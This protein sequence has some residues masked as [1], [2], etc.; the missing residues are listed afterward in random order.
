[1]PASHDRPVV[2]P[3]AAERAR[4]LPAAPIDQSKALEDFAVELETEQ[5]GPETHGAVWQCVKTLTETLE[6]E[7]AEALRRSRSRASV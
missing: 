6:P 3:R 5:S 4:R 1:M 2:L 7:Y